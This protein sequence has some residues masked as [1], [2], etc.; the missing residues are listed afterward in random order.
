VGYDGGAFFSHDG[1]RIVWRAS[2]PKDAAEKQSYLD[3]LKTDTIRPTQL[4]IYTADAGGKHVRQLTANGA[5]NFCP[6]FSP[7]DRWIIFASNVG[8][9]KGRNF[10]LW[11]I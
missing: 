7:D 5:A 8:D 11:R 1:K 4:E 10:D 3:L 9:P 6:Y 2:R